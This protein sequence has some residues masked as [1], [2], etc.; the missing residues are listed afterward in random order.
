[1]NSMSEALSEALE[2]PI[3]DGPRAR[4]AP[5]KGNA[6]RGVEQGAASDVVLWSALGAIGAIALLFWRFQRK[7]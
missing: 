3:I 6:A 1:M 4:R 2:H 7:A 5:R